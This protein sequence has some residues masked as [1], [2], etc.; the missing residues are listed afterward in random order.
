[1]TVH[2]IRA[3][4]NQHTEASGWLAL[5]IVGAETGGASSASIARGIEGSDSAR[6]A[7]ES[8]RTLSK[9]E[10]SSFSSSLFT[11]GSLRVKASASKIGF[12]PGAG[13]SSL[14]SSF[15]QTL[16]MSTYWNKFYKLQISTSFLNKKVKMFTTYRTIRKNSSW[17]KIGCIRVHI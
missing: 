10:S 3:E 11:F 1:M 9:G 5:D 2:L 16:L 8:P 13:P 12:I 6:L 4:G 17:S 14:S 15:K 7:S